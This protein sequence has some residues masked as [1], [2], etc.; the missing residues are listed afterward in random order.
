MLIVCFFIFKFIPVTI[1]E[2]INYHFTQIIR[3]STIYFLNKPLF[4][5]AK[6]MIYTH[7]TSNR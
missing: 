7:I 6:I 3:H 4:I 5:F 1:L 2:I